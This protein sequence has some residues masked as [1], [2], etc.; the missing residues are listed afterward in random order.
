MGFESVGEIDP[1]IV[2]DVS[3]LHY[4][5]RDAYLVSRICR[6]GRG[7][8]QGGRKNR[9]KTGKEMKKGEGGK[10]S[11]LL[12]PSSRRILFGDA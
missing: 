5:P 3:P 4:L 1:M 8:I 12:S 6:K 7:K 9:G 11:P 10:R 2:L